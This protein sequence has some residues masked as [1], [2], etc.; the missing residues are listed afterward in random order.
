MFLIKLKCPEPEKIHLIPVFSK[1][2]GIPQT[3]PAVHMPFCT[4]LR[5]LANMATSHVTLP[6][7]ALSYW[8]MVARGEELV[9]SSTVHGC[10]SGLTPWRQSVLQF[11]RPSA[12][13]APHFKWD[14][15][16]IVL[17]LRSCQWLSGVESCYQRVVTFPAALLL[18]LYFCTMHVPMF[19]SL[20][21]NRG[22]GSR[23]ICQVANSPTHKENFENK[24]MYHR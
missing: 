1:N 3:W 7:A 13:Q 18:N 19:L 4:P 20:L 21:C 14:C 2:S 11:H 6:S 9:L 5:P 23:S 24:F 22:E 16:C 15:T 8:C 17:V 12:G 10:Y